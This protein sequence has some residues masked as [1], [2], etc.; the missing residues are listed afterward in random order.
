M[1]G[2]ISQIDVTPFFTVI[3]LFTQLIMLSHVH[4]GLYLIYNILKSYNLKQI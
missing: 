3:C 4:S 1:G 2:K